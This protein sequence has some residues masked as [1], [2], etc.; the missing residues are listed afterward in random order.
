MSLYETKISQ[1]PLIYRGKVRDIYDLGNELLIVTT[2]RLSAFDVILKQPIPKKGF[3]LTQLTNFWLNKF[4]DLVPTQSTSRPLS[5]LNLDAE[6]M[7]KIEGQAVVVKKAKPVLVEC[8]V[9]GYLLGSGYKDYLKTGKVCGIDL[10]QGLQLAQKLPEPIFTPSTKADIGEHDENIGFDD[11]IK[12]VGA[13]LAKKLKETSLALYSKASAFAE[14]R[15]II[16]ADTKFEFGLVDGE[17]T[18]IDE[19]LTPDSSR[20]WNKSEY[21]VGISPPSFDK[22]IVRD[23]LESTTW[24]KVAPAPDLPEEIILK[25]SQKYQDVFNI[26]TKN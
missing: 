18:L 1:Y 14:T 25:T 19:V 6:T 16:I 21:A 20:F 4:K 15:G 26:L 24:N 9:R 7:H 22:Q 5:D 13:D 12:L 2:D 8:V 3:V 17:L 23:Y 10:P 11:V